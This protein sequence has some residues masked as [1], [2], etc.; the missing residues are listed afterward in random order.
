M[1][2]LDQTQGGSSLFNYYFIKH[3]LN[4]NYSVN[5]TLFASKNFYKTQVNFKNIIKKNKKLKVSYII[6]KDKYKFNFK[7]NFFLE[8]INKIFYYKELL[9]YFLLNKNKINRNDIN[10]TRGF[11]F[12]CIFSKL[13]IKNINLL[14]DP[15]VLQVKRELLKSSDFFFK[16][17]RIIV[18]LFL[19]NIYK[20]M[21]FYFKLNNFCKFYTHSPHHVLYFNEN[22]IK[23]KH[24]TTFQKSNQLSYINEVKKFLLKNQKRNFINI[25]FV[26]SLDTSAS[27]TSIETSLVLF[28]NLNKKIKI[29]I[30]FLSDSYK[31]IKNIENV[32]IYFVKKKVKLNDFMKKMHFGIYLG[33]YNIGIRQRIIFMMSYGVPVLCHINNKDSL[34]FLTNNKDIIYYKDENDLYKIFNKL[35]LNQSFLLKLKINSFFSQR[36]FYDMKKNLE[37]FY[38]EIVKKFQY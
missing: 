12:A 8:S 31:K 24:I 38:K 13:N 20:K 15:K 1:G 33:D 18:Y 9:N 21:S 35:C 29:N 25:C 4:K 32:N 16:I 5:A 11:G 14:D 22:N 36:K 37:L 19:K 2:S 17:K 28:K 26:G 6:L 34:I 27:K 7:K 3:L 23:C 30:F 10:V